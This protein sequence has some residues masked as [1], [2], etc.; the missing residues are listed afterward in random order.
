MDRRPDSTQGS[1]Q[2]QIQHRD[3]FRDRQFA[4]KERGNACTGLSRKY[5]IKV[6]KKLKGYVYCLTRNKESASFFAVVLSFFCFVLFFVPY[7]S[8]LFFF[9][10][11]FVLFCFFSFCP[12]GIFLSF[13]S[14]PVLFCFLLKRRSLVCFFLFSFC[15]VS[16]PLRSGHT[17]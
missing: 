2:G 16:C 13:V 9:C 6:A 17:K 3:Q 5:K 4:E 1:I 10:P 7:F 12:P 14:F 8:Y 11:C 15:F